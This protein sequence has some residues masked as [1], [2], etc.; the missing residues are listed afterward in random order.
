MTISAA[1][2]AAAPGP[3]NIVVIL[4]DDLGWRDVGYHGSE[5]STPHLDAL[6]AG[7][8]ILNQ[9]HSQPTCTPTRAAL[10]TGK[11][12]QRLGIYRQFAKNSTEGLPVTERTLADHLRQAGYQTWLVGK[13]HLGHARQEFHPNARGFDHFYGHVTGGIGYWDHVH[14][15]GLDWQRNGTTVR[16]DGYTTDLLTREALSLIEQ[17]DRN[18]PFF[19][20]ASFNAPHLPNEAPENAIA[21][22]DHIEA[23]FRRVHAAMVSE[24]D[25]AIGRLVSVLEQSGELENTLIWFMSDNGGLNRDV[26]SAGLVSWSERLQDWFGKPLPVTILEFIRT[27][28]LEGG[29]DNHPLRAGKGSVYQGGARVPALLHWRGKLPVHQ[30]E[31]MMTVQDVLPTLLHVTGAELPADLDG[32]NL[33]PALTRRV[34]HHPGA[35]LTRGQRGDQA[36]YKWPWKLVASDERLEL[37][38]LHDDP[39]ETTDLVAQQPEQVAA[40]AQQLQKMPRAE[41]LHIPLYQVFWD[42]DF[43]GGEE[44]R[45]PWADVIEPSRNND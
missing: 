35:Y 10:M 36:Y 6:A 4:A 17:R 40:M 8:V 11:S 27:N 14:G 19:L 29:A 33:W 26:A 30:A 42:P 16:E 45:M 25:R 5:I 18:R 13:W 34:K 32:Q 12:P 20:Y 7:G 15:G 22:Y 24:L 37:Y 2:V 38:N 43:F 44:D 39:L 28:S 3:P 31:A 21:A 9:F 1:A 23:P 41:S